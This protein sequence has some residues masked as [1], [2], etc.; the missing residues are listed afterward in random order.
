MRYPTIEQY[1]HALQAPDVTVL[2]PLLASGEVERGP[3][4]LPLARLGGYALTFKISAG[5]RA[6]ALRC[7]LAE[8][9]TFAERIRALSDIVTSNPRLPLVDL[10]WLDRGLGLNGVDVPAIRMDWVHGEPLGLH[11]ERVHDDR[12]ALDS[13][14]GQLRRLATE[15]TDAGFA[16]G[17]L[18]TFNI[19]VEPDGG[20]RLIDYDGY[21]AAPTAHLGPLESGH[22]NFQ[23]PRRR[24]VGLYGP[25]LD[26]FSLLALDTALACL[27]ED[28]DLWRFTSS[29]AEALVFRADDFADPSASRVF[30]R[31]EGL[32]DAGDRVRELEAISRM[33]PRFLPPPSALLDD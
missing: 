28:S 16:H 7:L 27:M 19:I 9:P 29:G 32:T 17:D 24:E 12:D 21:Y 30:Q 14:R 3:M 33:D 31:T 4:G 25:N 18:H 11:L 26:S 13:V 2:D 20:L 15:L 6:F 10:R 8:R 5:E 23:H 1:L 22:G